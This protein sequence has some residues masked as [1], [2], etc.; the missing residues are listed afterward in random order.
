MATTVTFNGSTYT[1]PANG[2]TGWGSNVLSYLTAISTGC[3]QLSGGTSTLTAELDLG[4]SFGLKALYLKS[5]T[6]SAASSGVL[7]LAA[8]DTIAWRN[9]GNNGDDVLGVSTDILQWNGSNIITQA[10]QRSGAGT[11]TW[12]CQSLPSSA[13]ATN[14]LAPFGYI[15]FLASPEITWTVPVNCTAQTLEIRLQTATT[16]GSTTYTLRKNGSDTALTATLATG[17]TSG[18]DLTHSVSCVTGDLLSLKCATGT[19]VS[20]GG[21]HAV[22]SVYLG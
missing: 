4:V 12:A 22:I 10:T 21:T 8:G 1:L 20:A 16:G 6:A 5:E 19:G 11:M 18:S 3:L 15:G 7:K 13:N 9:A 17:V 14:F 2:D